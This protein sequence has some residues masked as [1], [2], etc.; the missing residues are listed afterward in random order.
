MKKLAF[1]LLE[2]TAF[3]TRPFW[4]VFFLGITFLPLS[5][6]RVG[7]TNLRC[8]L[9]ARGLAARKILAKVHQ[10]YA[11]YFIELIVLW[12]L[13]LLRTQDEDAFGRLVAEIRERYR[14][15]DDQGIV[16]MAAH[17]GNIE[18]L[19]FAMRRQF[20]KRGQKPFCVLAKPSRYAWANSLLELVREKRGFLVLWTGG[21][22]FAQEFDELVKSGKGIALAIDQK[23]RKGG[24]FVRFFQEDAAFPD[25]GVRKGIG[26]GMVF[27]H[28]TLRRLS[29]GRFQMIC[30]EGCNSHHSQGN[31]KDAPI[32]VSDLLVADVLGAYARWLEGVIREEPG[33][34]SWD[35]RKWSRKN[36]PAQL[37]VGNPT[38]FP[39]QES[40]RSLNPNSL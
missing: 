15:R 22:H 29:L 4:I 9:G 28:A 1:A 40:P 2:F 36:T 25:K 24:M 5:A 27:V 21:P 38:T 19:G 11:C 26:Q 16:M 3:L 6:N 23:P 7:M 33:Q 37:S 20:A 10:Q 34:W 31:V 30:E 14:L 35:Y 32:P 13:G 17:Y 39:S 18:A 8:Q 12:P